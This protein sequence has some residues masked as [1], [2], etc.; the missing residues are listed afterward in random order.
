MVNHPLNGGSLPLTG[1]PVVAPVTRDILIMRYEGSV[2]GAGGQI[3]VRGSGRVQYE[4]SIP[5][6]SRWTG[7]MI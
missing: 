2:Q 4:E 6:A 1:G 3:S 5:E 7:G